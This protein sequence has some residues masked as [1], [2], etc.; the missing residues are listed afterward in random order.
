MATESQGAA[1]TLSF[2]APPSL[3]HCHL[4]PSPLQCKVTNSFLCCCIDKCFA[5]R[6]LLIWQATRLTTVWCNQV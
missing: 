1:T 4:C 5:V 2:P 6:K 3:S